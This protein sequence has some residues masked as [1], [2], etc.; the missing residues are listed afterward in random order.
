[1]S[2]SLKERIPDFDQ[3]TDASG[4]TLGGALSQPGLIRS[5][6][7]AL[8]ILALAVLIIGGIEVWLR[9]SGT[10]SYIFPKP[11]EIGAALVDNFSLFWPHIVSTITVLLSSRLAPD[12]SSRV[13]VVRLD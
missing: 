1:M 3:R 5:G 2:E 7:Q 10:E 8:A 6:G 11:S 9:A 13:W 12:V 4:S